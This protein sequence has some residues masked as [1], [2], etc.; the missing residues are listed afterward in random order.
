MANLGLKAL[1]VECCCWSGTSERRNVVHDLKVGLLALHIE[2]V[3]G[4]EHRI[5]P[6]AARA[7]ALFGDGM[8][9]S[10]AD[11]KGLSLSENL[12]FLNASPVNVDLSTMTDEHAAASIARAWLQAVMLKLRR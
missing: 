3:A 2:N 4:H 11:A 10:C 5:R 6:I 9:D 7:A 8:Q 12:G 1:C